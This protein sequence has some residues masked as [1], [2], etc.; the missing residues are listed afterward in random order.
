MALLLLLIVCAPRSAKTQIMVDNQI[1]NIMMMM[2]PNEG[3]KLHIFGIKLLFQSYIKQ[4]KCKKKQDAFLALNA[5]MDAF[6]MFLKL[7]VV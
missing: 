3:I 5:Q 6:Q 7:A 2:V 4:R 1:S